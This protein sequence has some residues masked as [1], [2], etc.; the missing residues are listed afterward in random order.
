MTSLAVTKGSNRNV[1]GIINRMSEYLIARKHQVV[2]LNPD[3]GKV[4]DDIV[5]MHLEIL[6]HVLE[7]LKP[8]GGEKYKVADILSGSDDNKRRALLSVSDQNSILDEIINRAEDHAKK[9]TDC[10]AISDMRTLF[11]AIDKPL[12]NIV[13]LIQHW[14]MWDL[15]DASDLHHFDTLVMRLQALLHG[16]LSEEI[17]G[18]YRPALAKRPD[19]A[20]ADEDVLRFELRQMELL[21]NRFLN[22]RAEDE[23]YQMIIRREKSPDGTEIPIDL[24]KQQGEHLH[25]VLQAEKAAVEKYVSGGNPSVAPQSSSE[26]SIDTIKLT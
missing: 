22:H 26:Q 15:S 16:G 8:F 2:R 14:M 12:E 1:D 3:V 25:S 6:L 17:K 11:R 13:I 5:W 10:G 24:K 18:R 21:V 7:K 20:V 19:E 9:S 4:I 23:A